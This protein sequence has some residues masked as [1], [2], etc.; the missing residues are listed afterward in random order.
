MTYLWIYIIGIGIHLV[1]SGSLLLIETVKQNDVPEWE[2][3]AKMWA[4]SAMWPACWML[5]IWIKSLELIR[6]A[7]HGTNQP[8]GDTQ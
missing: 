4:W 5:V 1:I 2:V 3:I 6:W 8:T 7:F